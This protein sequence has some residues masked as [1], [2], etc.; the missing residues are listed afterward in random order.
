MKSYLAYY[1]IITGVAGGNSGALV[2]K[3]DS[4]LNGQYISVQRMDENAIL[5]VCE[6]HV[7][8][9]KWPVDANLMSLSG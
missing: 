2:V 9:S 5:T 7:M 3:C 1:I 8:Q 4:P 6:I